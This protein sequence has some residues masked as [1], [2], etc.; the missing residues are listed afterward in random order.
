MMAVELT[1]CSLKHI[2]VTSILLVLLRLIA[3]SIDC[4][5][6]K[7]V[8]GILMHSLIEPMLKQQK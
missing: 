8:V 6:T 3:V 4:P 2:F 7:P 1:R 5:G